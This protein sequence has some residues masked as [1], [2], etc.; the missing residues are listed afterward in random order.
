M[1]DL[2]ERRLQPEDMDRPDLGEADFVGSLRALE[3]INWWSGSAGILW[4]AIRDLAATSSTPL[5]VLDIATGAGDVPIRLWHKAQHAG[6]ALHVEGCDR[7]AEAVRHAASRAQQAGA[8]VR[9][10][11]L[12]AVNDPLPDDFDIIATSLFLHHLNE[13]EAVDLLGRMA[14]AARRLVLVNDLVRSALGFFLGRASG[15]PA[16]RRGR[17]HAG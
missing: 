13:E 15:W 5:R 16:L 6:I 4:P 14:Q 8:S 9:Y 12:D 17:V 7:K 1:P 3:R 2:R 11:Q 10:F